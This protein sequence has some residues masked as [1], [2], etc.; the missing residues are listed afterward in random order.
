MKQSVEVEDKRS[1]ERNHL[2]GEMKFGS[3]NLGHEVEDDLN[4]C[5]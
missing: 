5:G 2:G 3:W 4:S 1:C